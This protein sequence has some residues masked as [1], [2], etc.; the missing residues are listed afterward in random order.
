LGGDFLG[1]A[2]CFVIKKNTVYRLFGTGNLVRSGAAKAAQ[3]KKRAFG[4]APKDC[5]TGKNG[6]ATENRMD[7]VQSGI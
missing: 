1:C 3:D 6:G 7:L 2:P 4:Q 5:L